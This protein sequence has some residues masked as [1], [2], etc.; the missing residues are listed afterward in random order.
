M[1]AATRQRP[2][3]TERPRDRVIFLTDGDPTDPP[4]R[5]RTSHAAHAVSASLPG[6]VGCR[7]G[8]RA[9]AERVGAGADLG[10]RAAG[11]GADASGSSGAHDGRPSTCATA[12]VL[13][14]G[15][16]RAD[17]APVHLRLRRHRLSA[18]RNSPGHASGLRSARNS[19][20]VCEDE[21]GFLIGGRGRGLGL[22]SSACTVASEPEGVPAPRPESVPSGWERGRSVSPA[23]GDERAAKSM[24]EHTDEIRIA[25]VGAGQI[26]RSR[27]LPG[28]RA[29]PG[30][31]IVGVCNQKRESAA[32]VARE[33]AIPKVYGG[34]E[35]A[36]EDPDVNAVLIGRV[37]LPALSGHSGSIR[38]GQARPDAGAH[39]DERPR[40]P[41]HV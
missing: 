23:E 6:D 32:R 28:F 30:V 39:G 9:G 21:A 19:R 12:D 22:R 26:T 35:E 4:F 15:L 8:R 11:P 40:S 29:I 18:A 31:R 27:H 24:G 1:F 5:E 13:G 10:Q 36:V 16:L 20:V 2:M 34:W 25:V 3:L 7:R 33:F 17:Q 14:S 37:A 41:A 38:R